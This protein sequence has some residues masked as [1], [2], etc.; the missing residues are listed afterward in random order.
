MPLVL[1]ESLLLSLKFWKK[2]EEWCTFSGD[3]KI[4]VRERTA[5]RERVVRFLPL[6][7]FVYLVLV[8][9]MEDHFLPYTAACC[10]RTLQDS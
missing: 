8:G 9:R 6:Y 2:L 3:T 5:G 7:V 10:M 1:L 4:S